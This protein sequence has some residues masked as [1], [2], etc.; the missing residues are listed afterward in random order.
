MNSNTI[1]TL[2]RINCDALHEKD[3]QPVA[4][5]RDN[6]RYYA[7]L[8]GYIRQF[9]HDRDIYFGHKE[10]WMWCVDGQ[11]RQVDIYF[12]EEGL[13]NNLFPNHRANALIAAGRFTTREFNDTIDRSD[14]EQERNLNQELKDHYGSCFFVGD[15]VCV[16][17]DGQPLPDFTVYGN[18][19]IDFV[20]A[21]RTPSQAMITQFGETKARNMIDPSKKY[22][23]MSGYTGER[24]RAYLR[25]PPYEHASYRMMPFS[26][27][28]ATNYDT[29]TALLKS[30]GYQFE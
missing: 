29:Y 26:G 22:K 1:V 15:V 10:Y 17:P 9:N 11:R 8:R 12:D 18:N 21:D 28:S 3:V 5:S 4:I 30:W 6:D 13:E 20:L 14:G 19:P 27:R 24:L 16:I 7:E 25:N 23:S 2:I